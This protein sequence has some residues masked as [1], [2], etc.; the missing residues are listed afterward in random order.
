[1]G[2]GEHLD[3]LGERG[4]PGD[5]AVMG[6]VEADQLDQH[7]RIA[8]VALD[9]GRA[10]S[11]AVAGHLQRID[12]GDGV[13]GG[14][15]G[16]HPRPAVGLDPDDHLLGLGVLGQ[17]IGDQGMQPGQPV[18]PL[19]QP[20]AGQPTTVLIDDLDVVMGLGPVVPDKQ[21]RISLRSSG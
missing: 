20:P 10:V 6:P 3:V 5:R 8:G 19:G 17:V 14:D 4:V 7:V 16:L 2:A 13:A 9:P 11:F 21:H 18:D 15:Q 12:R 1:M